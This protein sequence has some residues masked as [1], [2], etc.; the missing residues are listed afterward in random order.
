MELFFDT[1]TTGLPN[2]RTPDSDPSQPDIVQLGIILADR[3]RIYSE[4]SLI[5]KPDWMFNIHPRAEEVH[6]IS[7]E[8]VSLTG[9]STHLALDLF[10]AMLVHADT[11]VCHNYTFDLKLMSI[12]MAKDNRDSLPLKRKKAY[13]TMKGSTDICKLPGN[14]GKYKWP[15]LQELHKH[16]FGVEF[17]GAHDALEDVRATRRCYYKMKG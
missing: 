11:V 13:C 7:L 4:N 12:A 5:I 17:D 14:Y 3:N 6:G 1:E 16:L 10:E 15:K 9:V 2:K 8:V